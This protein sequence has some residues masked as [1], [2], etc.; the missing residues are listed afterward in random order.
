MA[1]E[2]RIANSITVNKGNVKNQGIGMASRFDQVGNGY[3]SGT[4][5]LASTVE[6]SLPVDELTTPGFYTITVN[7]LDSGAMVQVGPDATGIVPMD[8]LEMELATT[9]GF[10]NTGSVIKIVAT[11]GDA[12][13]AFFVA[14]E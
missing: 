11:G 13:I 3:Q 2:I 4:I 7:S 14:E 9:S 12:Q 8:S 5:D 1:N 6:I 10:I